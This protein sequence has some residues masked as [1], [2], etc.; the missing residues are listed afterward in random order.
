[1]KRITHIGKA[2][3]GK[4]F[5][6]Y[7]DVKIIRFRLKGSTMIEVI[8][9]SV[10][11]MIVFIMAIEIITRLS[12]FSNKTNGYI[13]IE[14]DLKSTAIKLGSM[15]ISENEQVF[16]YE[17]GEVRAHLTLYKENIYRIDML[18]VPTKRQQNISYTFLLANK[19]NEND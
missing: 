3:I 13:A 18:A 17:W 8:T 7:P 2:Y 6:R 9:A 14:R 4:C 5:R 1:M 16:H 12:L 15:D 11:F 19:S 10:I